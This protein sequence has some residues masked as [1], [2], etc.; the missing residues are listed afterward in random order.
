MSV[1]ETC[2][3]TGRSGLEFVSQTLAPSPIPAPAP[4]FS[5]PPLIKSPS[6]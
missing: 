5:L 4:L 6:A 2:K 1:L 3:R